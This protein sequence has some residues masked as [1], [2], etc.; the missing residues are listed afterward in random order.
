MPLRRSPEIN[1]PTTC[2]RAIGIDGKQYQ[3]LEITSTIRTTSL[4]SG[5]EE[6][7]SGIAKWVLSDGLASLNR[8][9]PNTFSTI[10]G[11]L[12]VELVEGDT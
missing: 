7:V 1:M 3:V 9:G 12:T 4:D 10:D 8:T 11:S 2:H 6:R 5:Y